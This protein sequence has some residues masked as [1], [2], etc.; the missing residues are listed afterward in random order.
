MMENHSEGN[1]VL[2]ELYTR[3]RRELLR[4][5]SQLCRDPA[6]AEDLVQ[7]TFLKAIS[8]L[9][10]LEGLGAK[11]RRAWLYKVAKNRFYDRCRKRKTEQEHPMIFEEET[12]GGFSEIETSMILAVLP[13]ELASVFFK[14]YIEG[15]TS[16]E[17]AEEYG[18]SSSGIRAMLSRARKI[19]REKLTEKQEEP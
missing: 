9:D 13:P 5:C 16:R 17:L 19:L 14:R 11:E 3:Y 2:I 8:S 4:Y 15:Y 1:E 12:D 6:E 7:E 10:L 18:L